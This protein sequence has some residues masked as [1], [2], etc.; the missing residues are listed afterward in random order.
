MI[1]FLQEKNL[2][3]LHEIEQ[4]LSQNFELKELGEVSYVIG[5]EIRR[6]RN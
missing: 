4:F 1:F 3:L 5:V 6:D 2:G